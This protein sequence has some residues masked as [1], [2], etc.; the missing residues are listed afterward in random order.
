MARTRT[1]VLSLAPLMFMLCTQAQAGPCKEPRLAGVSEEHPECR[2]FAGTRL[3]RERNFAGAKAKW[4]AVL[5]STEDDKEIQRLRMPATI[6]AT[7][8]TWASGSRRID[9]ERWNCG[10]S[11][12][13]LGRRS[14]PIT[15]VMPWV[16]QPNPSTGPRQR[17][18]TAKRHCGTTSNRP[19]RMP[20]RRQ[21]VANFE[22]TSAALAAG[23]A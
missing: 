2:F 21:S 1:V 4:E 22:P 15:Y 8:C 13:A 14:R 12:H 3:F 5:S 16:T 11:L 23:D 17:C 18:L 10:K 19:Q 9:V 6:L 20:T 7:C